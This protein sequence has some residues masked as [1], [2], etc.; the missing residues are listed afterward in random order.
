MSSSSYSALAQRT[1]VAPNPKHHKARTVRAGNGRKYQWWGSSTTIGVSRSSEDLRAK[2]QAAAKE[3]PAADEL[4]PTE[5]EPKEWRGSFENDADA[6]KSFMGEVT[7]R[8]EGEE[9][10]F[11]VVGDGGILESTQPMPGEARFAE[12][13]PKGTCCTI[14]SP[15]KDFEAHVMLAK[16]KEVALARSERGG[17]KIYAVRLFGDSGE[18]A[19]AKSVMTILLNG[20]G[21]G[22]VPEEAIEK[23]ESLATCLPGA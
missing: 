13:G 5:W 10:R 4:P 15:T 23:W 21:E 9:C 17:R 6:L 16:V 12:L 7:R 14:A 20:L 22:G 18:D 2:A 11:I 1:L 19:P 3:A 8:L